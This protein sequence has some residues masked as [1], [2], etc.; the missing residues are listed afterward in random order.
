MHEPA[1]RYC[2]HCGATPDRYRPGLFPVI[3]E[4]SSTLIC[5]TCA[6][7]LLAR[8]ERAGGLT[9]VIARPVATSST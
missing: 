6:L 2:G 8:Y 9:I 3:D 5:S 7:S 4:C 1:I